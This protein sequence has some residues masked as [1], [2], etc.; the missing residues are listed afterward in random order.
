M[1]INDTYQ[2]KY[3]HKKAAQWQVFFQYRVTIKVRDCMKMI[4]EGWGQKRGR[5]M[6]C[7]IFYHIFWRA[8]KGAYSGF[9]FIQSFMGK[10]IAVGI[11][12]RFT[13][14]VALIDL[15]L[16]QLFIHSGCNFIVLFLPLI[17]YFEILQ[18]GYCTFLLNQ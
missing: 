11:S 10:N 15:T 9:F 2:V 18:F 3:S 13:H 1:L 6:Y 12:A 14:L 17:Y 16:K 5:I 7:S 8:G 4:R